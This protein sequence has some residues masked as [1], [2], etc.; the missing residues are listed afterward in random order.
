MSDSVHSQNPSQTKTFS[1]AGGIT[2][3]VVC[4]G[5]QKATDIHMVIQLEFK[6]PNDPSV[7]KVGKCICD[8]KQ[9]V[10]LECVTMA[11][12]TARKN[13]VFFQVTDTMMPRLKVP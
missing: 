10:V 6:F 11:L 7:Y 12:I 2:M 9:R 13:N 3:E 1:L 5:K 4:H 8:E